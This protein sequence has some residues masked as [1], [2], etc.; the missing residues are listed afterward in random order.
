MSGHKHVQVPQHVHELVRNI[1]K[2][3]NTTMVDIVTKA[4]DQ[5][6]PLEQR[7]E[8]VV[9]QFF[10]NDLPEYG[11]EWD[12]NDFDIDGAVHDLVKRVQ[13]IINQR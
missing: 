5:Y 2:S 8:N 1:A 4:V 7:L 11:M 13:D 12:E 9:S 10:L 6:H 3:E